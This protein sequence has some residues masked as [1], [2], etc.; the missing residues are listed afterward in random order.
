MKE[1]DLNNWWRDPVIK[2]TELGSWIAGPIVIGAFLGK[3]LD[4]RYET[5]PWLFLLT[6]GI[7]FVISIT[8]LVKNTIAY[9]DQI[10]K[11]NNLK[12]NKDGRQ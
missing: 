9:M 11:S 8:G 10:D 12:N 5:S 6:I 4:N 3:W 2:F 7:A 1:Q